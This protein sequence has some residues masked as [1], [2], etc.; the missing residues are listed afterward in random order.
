MAEEPGRPQH[1]NAHGKIISSPNAAAG[2]VAASP[3]LSHRFLSV[4]F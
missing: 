3:L 2:A 4:I 1:P